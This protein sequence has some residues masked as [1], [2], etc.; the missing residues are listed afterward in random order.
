MSIFVAIIE[1]DQPVRHHLTQII[2]SSSLCTL[3]GVAKNGAEARA[4][5]QEDNTD[6]Y[7]VDLGLPDANGIDIIALI[8][9][10]CQNARI[11][12]LSTFGDAKHVSQSIRAGATGYLL[13]DEPKSSLIEKIVSLHNGNSPISPIVANILIREFSQDNASLGGE[14]IRKVA[15]QKFGLS[16][17]EIEVLT[18]LTTGLSIIHISDRMNIS[19]HTVNQH[20]R[21]IYRKLNVRSRAMAVRVAFENGIASA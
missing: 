12:V 19:T 9:L 10:K 4:L 20:L 13:K 2:E 6:V 21:S 15:F 8:K 1:D 17:R 3:S 14:A 7:L 16:I 11:L 5:I 18:L